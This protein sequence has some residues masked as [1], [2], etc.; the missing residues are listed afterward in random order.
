MPMAASASSTKVLG[1]PQCGQVGDRVEQTDRIETGGR[2]IFTQAQ[3][4]SLRFRPVCIRVGSRAFTSRGRQV[5]GGPQIRCQAAQSEGSSS[6]SETTTPNRSLL[7][8]NCDGNGAVPCGQCKGTGVNQEDKFDGRFKAGQTCWLCRGK[9]QMLCGE[10][11]GAG[12]VGGFM[13]TQ[14][15]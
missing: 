8:Q 12:F 11:N 14:S 10:C 6:P 13:S 1:L 15:D 9:R 4:K 3:Q 7:C 5:E 2:S